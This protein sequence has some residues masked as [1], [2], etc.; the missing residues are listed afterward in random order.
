MKVLVVGGSGF[1]GSAT[2]AALERRGIDVTVMRAPRLDPV[3]PERAR[4]AVLSAKLA[5]TE[6]IEAMA[7]HDVV[8]NTAGQPDASSRDVGPLIAANSVLPAVLAWAAGQA[9]VRRFLHVSSAAVQGQAPVLDQTGDRRPFSAYS[10]AKALGEELLEELSNPRVVIYRPPG[11]HGPDRRITCI[12]S[13]VARSPLSTVA[14]PGTGPTPQSHIDNVSD[15]IAY[16]AICEADVPRV[17]IHPWEGFS[18]AQFMQMLGGAPPR[19]LPRWLTGLITHGLGLAGVLIPPLVAN[20]R[21]LDMMWHGQAQAPSWLTD[22]GWSPPA[23][24]DE[25]RELARNVR[26][27]QT[28]VD[29][30]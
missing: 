12:L 4:A 3:A 24:R 2:S 17:V 9:G 16:L 28:K 8:V 11:V 30:L 5:N 18:T 14:S 7:G 19:L 23:G 29:K 25:W 1:V 27:N 26:S 22:Q 15:A 6:L 20:A 21:R 13:R 10:Q